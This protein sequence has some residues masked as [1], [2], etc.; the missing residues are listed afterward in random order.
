[1]SAG[2][3]Y[4]FEDDPRYDGPPTLGEAVL[5][6]QRARVLHLETLERLVFRVAG[7]EEGV[8]EIDGV[9]EVEAKAL[10]NIRKRLDVLELATGHDAAA[11]TLIGLGKRLDEIEQKSDNALSAAPETRSVTGWVSDV[12]MDLLRV[13]GVPY[14]ASRENDLYKHPVTITFPAKG[15]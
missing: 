1:M 3:E 4:G 9:N 11:Q 6:L 13:G 2:K 15:G 8:A 12:S 7:L 14:V 10:Q 5:N